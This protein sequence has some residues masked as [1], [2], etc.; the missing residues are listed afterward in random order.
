MR[1]FAVSALR[2]PPFPCRRHP[3]VAEVARES[4][5]WAAEIG[6]TGG[7]ASRLRL[8]GAAVADLAGRACPEAPVDRLRLLTDLITWLFAVDDACDEDGLGAAPTRLAP[9]VA[10]L[11][12]VLDLR[13]DPAPP[14]LSGT[15]GP[16][17]VALHD[18]CRRV[19][20]H[21]Q[22]T[23]LLAFTGQL[24]EYLLALLWEA[25]NREHRRVP[26]VAEYV[27]MRRHTGGVHPSF[28]LTD[29]A[30]DGPGAVDRTDPALAALETLAADLVCWCNDVFS[31]RKEGR[32]TGD[33]HNL[34][35][36]IAGEKGG[37]EQA[38]LL[39]AA[40]LFN[41]ALAAY[42]ERETAVLRTADPA[43]RRFAAAR[44][45][46]IRATYDWSVSAARYA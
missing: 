40:D 45:C 18:L 14:A 2:E 35:A 20:A 34:V 36:A 15:A 37:P 10:G 38:A 33:G 23:V 28:T 9:A 26:G 39:A 4:A 16:H 22:P 1:S 13:G 3:L 11:L 24:R 7:A 30:Y 44:R 41:R 25:A 5:G 27:Q 42:T 29:L 17:G 21:A 12:D 32:L 43:T 31:Y 8:A 46:W 6:L 19:R